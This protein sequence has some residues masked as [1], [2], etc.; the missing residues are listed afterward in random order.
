MT[1]FT[2]HNGMQA[3]EGELSQIV[4]EEYLLSPRVLVVTHLASFPFLPLVDIVLRVTAVAVG[5][6]FFPFLIGRMAVVTGK[7]FVGATQPEFRIPIV[8]EFDLLP[9]GL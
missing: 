8:V 1:L 3:D 7:L 6:K 9:A 2:G 5:F 4:I